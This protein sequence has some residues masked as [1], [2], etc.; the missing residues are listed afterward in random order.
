[1]SLGPRGVAAGRPA[2]SAQLHASGYLWLP[3]SFSLRLHYVASRDVTYLQSCK[4]GKS[5][6]DALVKISVG[7]AGVRRGPVGQSAY[8]GRHPC[9]GRN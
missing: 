4:V 6:D 9:P 1:M 5:C 8:G 3:P 7:S 2:T